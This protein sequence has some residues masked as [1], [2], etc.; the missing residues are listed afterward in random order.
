MWT[1]CYQQRWSIALYVNEPKNILNCVPTSAKDRFFCGCWGN[2]AN[3]G[4]QSLGGLWK[5]LIME[6]LNFASAPS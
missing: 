1:E 3:L 4:I 6:F 2:W 5:L